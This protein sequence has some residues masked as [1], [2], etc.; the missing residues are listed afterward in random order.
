VKRRLPILLALSACSS[1]SAAQPPSLYGNWDSVGTDGTVRYDLT[2]EN[3]GKY[4]AS[5]L[6][7]T[8]L[9]SAN[10]QVETGFLTLHSSTV[11]FTP[12]SWSCPGST[13]PPYT[14]TYEFDHDDLKL[15]D[16]KGS[17]VF[18]STAWSADRA[19]GLTTGCF[20]PGKTFVPSSLSPLA[21]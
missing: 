19:F 10:A 17:R 2:V 16:M 20:P 5:L 3:D 21:P 14:A 7:L 18:Q 8:S 4:V 6:S 1:S 13:D 15:T 9:T 11:T 12:Q